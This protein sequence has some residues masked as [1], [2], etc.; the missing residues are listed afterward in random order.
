M[1]AASLLNL[2]QIPEVG[3]LVDGRVGLV[4]VWRGEGRA[5]VCI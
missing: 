5:E 4:C 1:Y 2:E 3:Y